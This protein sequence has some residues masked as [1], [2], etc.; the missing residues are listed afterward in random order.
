LA[1]ASSVGGIVRPS[2]FAVFRLITSSNLVDC[3]TGRSAGFPPVFG[4]LT[5]SDQDFAESLCEQFDRQG[6]PDRATVAGLMRWRRA[7]DGAWACEE[8][9]RC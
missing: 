9:P 2:V 7:G 3:T 1:I 8:L 6:L 4:A 5:W